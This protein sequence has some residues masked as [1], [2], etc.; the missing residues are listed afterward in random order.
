MFQKFYESSYDRKLGASW[1]G[2]KSSNEKKGP[3]LVPHKIFDHQSISSYPPC[4]VNITRQR[5]GLRSLRKILSSFD[6]DDP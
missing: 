3:C 1:H 2:R 5:T 4:L 6:H